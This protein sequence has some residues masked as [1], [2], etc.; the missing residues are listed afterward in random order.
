[1]ASTAPTERPVRVE[2]TTPTERTASAPQPPDAPDAGVLFPDMNPRVRR[3][4]SRLAGAVLLSLALGV[5]FSVFHTSGAG[6]AVPPTPSFGKDIDGYADYDPQSTCDPVAKPG[7]KAFRDLLLRAY[8]ETRDLGIVRACDVGGRSEHKEGRAFDWGVRANV[9]AERAD[10]E[11]VLRWLLATDDQGNRNALARRFGIMYVIWNH[12]IWS[13]ARADE[14]WRPYH[15]SDPHTD[16]VH[17]SFS[18]DGANM[19]TTWWTAAMHA[20]PNKVA[21]VAPAVTTA[22]TM[23]PAGAGAAGRAATTVPMT[24]APTTM[25]P[26]SAASSMGEASPPATDPEPGMDATNMP[27]P[28]GDQGAGDGGGA[29]MG[30]G[31]TTMPGNPTTLPADGQ[32][33]A[34]GPT[35]TSAGMLPIS[36]TGAALAGVLAVLLGIAGALLLVKGSMIPVGPLGPFGSRLGGARLNAARRAARAMPPPIAVKLGR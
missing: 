13:A 25:A 32:G 29:A 11:E 1:M 10:A 6:Y 22:T 20:A 9:P 14:G 12:R 34:P 3:R 33:D 36:G 17:V 2:P 31:P 19:R 16:H 8:P 18:W 30:P 27:A 5:G 23:P 15:G 28:A 24:M 7:V 21:P 26:A 35:T 4:R